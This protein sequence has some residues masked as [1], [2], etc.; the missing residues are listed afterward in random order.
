[1]IPFRWL[2]MSVTLLFGVTAAHAHAQLERADPRVGSVISAAP[3]AITLFFTEKIEPAFS[4][5][6]VTDAT[7]RRFDAGKIR[8]DR[9]NSSQAQ[10]SLKAIP[11][12]QY[13]VRWRVISVD[14]HRT[15]G[16]FTFEVRP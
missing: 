1:M 3:A 14:T 8:V 11:A 10:I 13:I 9:S 12:G 15:E 7:G 6:E 5:V 4:A 16:S 2:S